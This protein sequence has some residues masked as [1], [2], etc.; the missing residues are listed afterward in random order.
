ME[1]DFPA[2]I[3]GLGELLKKYVALK[4]EEALLKNKLKE[5]EIEK[6]TTLWCIIDKLFLVLEAYVALKVQENRRNRG[7]KE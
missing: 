7:E 1:V 2:E 6:I 4:R 5:I 3:K